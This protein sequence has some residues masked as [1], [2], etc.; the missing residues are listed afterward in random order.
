[1]EFGVGLLVGGAVW[2]FVLDCAVEHDLGTLSW[3]SA[4]LALVQTPLW[5]LTLASIVAGLWSAKT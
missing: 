2:Q 1:M 4:G 3:K 5:P